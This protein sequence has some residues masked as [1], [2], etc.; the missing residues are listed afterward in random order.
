[1]QRRSG[2]VRY[3]GYTGHITR[4]FA[5]NSGS[6][7]WARRQE[8]E[9]TGFGLATCH[10]SDSARAISGFALLLQVR[11]GKDGNYVPGLTLQTLE[12]NGSERWT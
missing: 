8:A 10:P 1:M 12:R 9:T 4:C 7:A 11:Q 5:G 2:S 3:T 6:S